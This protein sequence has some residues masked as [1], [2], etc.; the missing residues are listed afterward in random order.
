MSPQPPSLLGTQ[1]GPS[2][3][4]KNDTEFNPVPALTLTPYPFQE[5][6]YPAQ[7]GQQPAPLRQICPA[8]CGC[9]QRRLRQQHT[10]ASSQCHTHLGI[11]HTVV[12]GQAGSLVAELSREGRGLRRQKVLSDADCAHQALHL[13]HGGTGGAQG[14]EGKLRLKPY[15]PSIPLISKSTSLSNFQ[16]AVTLITEPDIPMARTRP[17]RCWST[18]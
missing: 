5:H 7:T 18:E 6:L 13:C 1:P 10:Q 2:R 4:K 12:R 11:K 8:Y 16:K 3:N 17:E 9:A 15:S 14:Q